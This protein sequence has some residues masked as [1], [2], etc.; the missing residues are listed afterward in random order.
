M[1][2][3]P[4][5]ELKSRLPDE[6]AALILSLPQKLRQ[7]IACIIYW[8]YFGERPTRDRWSHLDEWVFAPFPPFEPP[9]ETIAR[10]LMKCGYTPDQARHRVGMYSRTLKV[11]TEVEA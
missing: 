7:P 6:W 1:K 4:T 9:L 8:D 5:Q 10:A 3:R 11:S 2:K